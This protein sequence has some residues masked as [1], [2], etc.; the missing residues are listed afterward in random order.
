MTAQTAQY[1]FDFYGTH[2][3]VP[4]YYT[5]PAAA[6]LIKSDADFAGFK[7]LLDPL[8]TKP[9]IWIFD[10]RGMKTEHYMNIN[11]VRKMA[12]TIEHEHATS[13]QAVWVLN[14]DS[15]MRKMATLFGRKK[16]VPLPTERLELFVHMQKE[17]CPHDV[18]DR[19]IVAIQR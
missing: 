9:W 10:C 3:G 13:L 15:W 12:H 1:S 8:K 18:V 2:K 7:A 16:I 5:S 11:F 14:M 17:G 19:M 6:A 4:L